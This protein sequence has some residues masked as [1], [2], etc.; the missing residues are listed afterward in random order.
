ML[1]VKIEK[2]VPVTDARDNFNKIIDEVDATDE[3]YV[4]TKNGKPSAIVVGVHHLDKLTGG[5]KVAETIEPIKKSESISAMPDPL[6]KMDLPKIDLAPTN[7]PA[8]APADKEDDDMSIDDLFGPITD[9]DVLPSTT[10]PATNQTPATQT[11]SA[12]PAPAFSSNASAT[13]APTFKPAATSPWS[14]PT[15]TPAATPTA[16]SASTPTF[17]PTVTPASANPAPWTPVPTASTPATTVTNPTPSFR[18][19]VTPYT[20]AATPATNP[21]PAASSSTFRPTVAP[22]SANPAP[23]TPAPAANQSSTNQPIQLTPTVP[24]QSNQNSNNV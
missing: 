22:A 9:D 7:T 14:S 23:W 18:P 19:T 12:N 17:R 2:I 21:A 5:N 11:S 6:P 13:P 20:P 1:Q 10:P 4:I 15:N 3:L 8:P 16:P 24:A